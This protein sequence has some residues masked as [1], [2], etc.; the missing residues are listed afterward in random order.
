VIKDVGLRSQYLDQRLF[1]A[2]EVRDQ[3]LNH[4]AR[5][6]V[7]DSVN[8]PGKMICTSILKIVPSNSSDYH[9]P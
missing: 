2:I 7:S 5:I 4:D 9:V 6:R 1:S 3:Y 8:R